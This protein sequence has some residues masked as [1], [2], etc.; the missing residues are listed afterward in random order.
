[1]DN[2]KSF[3]ATKRT[4]EHRRHITSLNPTRDN[5]YALAQARFALSLARVRLL[6][7]TDKHGHLLLSAQRQ[8][9]AM[10]QALVSF[11]NYDPS[12]EQMKLEV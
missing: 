2:T 11:T 6:R 10:K 9:V 5:C 3:A 7:Q 8:V 12:V 4:Y 1:M